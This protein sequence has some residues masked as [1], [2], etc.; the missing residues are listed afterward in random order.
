V[1]GITDDE[2]AGAPS[3]AEVWPKVRRAAKGRT[4]LTYNANF[5]RGV[6]E[7]THERAGLDLAELPQEWGCLMQARSI[8]ARVGYR[9]ALGGSHRALGDARD[10][11]T[12]LQAIATARNP[13]QRR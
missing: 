11:R 5:D 6:M 7:R 12:V 8:R 2:L 1:H 3:W 13:D 9:I 10:A 4:I